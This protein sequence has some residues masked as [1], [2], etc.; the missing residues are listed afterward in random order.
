M[1]YVDPDEVDHEK[2]FNQDDWEHLIDGLFGHFVIDQVAP[3][4]WSNMTDNEKQ[5]LQEMAK[6]GEKID[7]DLQKVQDLMGKRVVQRVATT[8]GKWL[9]PEPATTVATS[10]SSS[11]QP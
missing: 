5:L 11:S 2:V 1:L 10:V 8:T 3:E 4:S 9:G 6:G 7:Y